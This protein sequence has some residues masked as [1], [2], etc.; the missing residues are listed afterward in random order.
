MLELGIACAALLLA[1]LALYRAYVPPQQR[2]VAELTA[3]VADLQES[4]DDFGRRLTGWKRGAG[5]EQA[6]EAHKTRRAASDTVL[7]EA[8]AVLEAVKAAPAAAQASPPPP[9]SKEALRA[10]FGIVR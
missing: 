7:A 6:R 2:R 9:L 3:N 10:Q 4:V 5:M 8:A 1:A